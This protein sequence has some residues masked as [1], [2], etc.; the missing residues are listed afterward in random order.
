MTAGGLQ[1]LVVWRPRQHRF[2][3]GVDFL[4]QP[5]QLLQIHSRLLVTELVGNRLNLCDQPSD[6]LSH[7][8]RQ[9]RVS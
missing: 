3:V 1:G 9:R 7:L 5:R 8:E 2:G 6:R 4:Q